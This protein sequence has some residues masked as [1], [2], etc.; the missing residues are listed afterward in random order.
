M[1]HI[2]KK[3]L[4]RGAWGAQSVKGPTLGFC[5][6]HNRRV[7]RLSLLSCSALGVELA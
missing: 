4:L 7:V 5:L 1:V 3:E 2:F 6:G